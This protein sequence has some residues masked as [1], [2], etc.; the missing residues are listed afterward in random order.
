VVLLDEPFSAL[1]AQVKGEL[2]REVGRQLA[3]AP[4]PTLLV[5]HQPEDA[6]ILGDRVVFLD[7]GRVKATKAMSENPFANQLQGS[8]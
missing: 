7:R 3:N 4:V 2:L 1:D 5:T 6:A 8:R